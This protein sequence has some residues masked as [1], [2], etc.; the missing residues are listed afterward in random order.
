VTRMGVVRG[1]DWRGVRLDTKRFDAWL[2]S[3][4]CVD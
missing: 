2:A 1:S 4:T 3:Q